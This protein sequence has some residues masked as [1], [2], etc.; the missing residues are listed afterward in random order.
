[1]IDQTQAAFASSRDIQ[2]GSV[3]SPDKDDRWSV[4]TSFV[5]RPVR[6]LS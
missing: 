6:P 5:N 1:M 2:P 3:L 4:L